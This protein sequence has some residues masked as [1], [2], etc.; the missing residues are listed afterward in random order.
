MAGSVTITHQDNRSVRQV[1]FAW[2][3]DASGDVSTGAG[4]TSF[5][6]SG[7]ILRITTDPGAT[8]PT[9]NYDVV[10][11]DAD[12]IDIA[13]G[14]LANRHTTNSESV[15]PLASTTLSGNPVASGCPVFVDG[16]IELVVSN[17]GNAKQ[18]TVRVYYR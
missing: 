17:A 10:I 2:T 16:T 13:M 3:S 8:A 11:N 7:E 4:L 1:V 18:G 9:A 15:V 12:G 5:S 14:F 6:I